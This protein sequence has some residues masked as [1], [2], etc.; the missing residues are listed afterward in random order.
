MLEFGPQE[1]EPFSEETL[2]RAEPKTA[3]GPRNEKARAVRAS[4]GARLPIER[5]DMLGGGAVAIFPVLRAHAVT[6]LRDFSSDPVSARECRN[7]VT[8]QLRLADAA[9][10]SA[11]NNDAPAGRGAFF[12]CRQVWPQEF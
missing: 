5:T 10:V 1:R 3:A 11:N 8:H 2:L 4:I 12:I 7:H 6:V 9:R